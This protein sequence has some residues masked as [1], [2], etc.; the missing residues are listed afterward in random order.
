[1]SVGTVEIAHCVMIP[2]GVAR[3]KGG[4]LLL[5]LPP[6]PPHFPLLLSFSTLFTKSSSGRGPISSA[7]Y[8]SQA[9]RELSTYALRVVCSLPRSYLY[10]SSSSGWK[11]GLL[12]N[13]GF[14]Q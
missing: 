3:G 7:E 8:G 10:P 9:L 2:H 4:L 13:G 5:R 1:M 11:S 14:P 6:L 12:I